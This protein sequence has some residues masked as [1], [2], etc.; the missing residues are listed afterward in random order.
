M[1]FISV[2]FGSGCQ[3]RVFHQPKQPSK[4]ADISVFIAPL[5][6]REGLCYALF[7]LFAFVSS[8]PSPFYISSPFVHRLLVCFPPGLV[9]MK[10][11]APEAR[12]VEQDISLT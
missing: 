3:G 7:I 5:A 6:E 12:N 1:S 10:N 2:W 11:T 8:I 9:R 4:T